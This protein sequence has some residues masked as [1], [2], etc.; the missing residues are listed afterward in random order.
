MT[1]FVLRTCLGT[2]AS[3]P[4]RG[5]LCVVGDGHNY[6]WFYYFERI[7]GKPHANP[8]L[9]AAVIFGLGAI[10]SLTYSYAFKD[11]EPRRKEKLK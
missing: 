5:T 4:A 6:F 3:S 9:F 2:A 10:G 8:E 11:R 7:S 1:I